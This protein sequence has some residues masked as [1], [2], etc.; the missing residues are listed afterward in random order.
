VGTFDS[1]H[2]EVEAAS[3]WIG[4]DGSVARV[5]EGT[6]LLAADACDVVL[7]A[8]ESLTFVG[9]EKMLVRKSWAVR[10][11]ETDLSLKEQNCWLMMSQTTSSDAM[12]VEEGLEVSSYVW[13]GLWW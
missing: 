13:C 2:V 5:G 10:E 7:I 9:S 1:L 11:L 4:T 3:G 12:A 8:A 6:C